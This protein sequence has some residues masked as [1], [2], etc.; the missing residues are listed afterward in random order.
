MFEVEK[1]VLEKCPFC[2]GALKKGKIE[3][4]DAKTLFNTGTFVNFVPEEDEGKFVRKN[5]ISLRQKADG[6]Y[7]DE[8]VQ[9]FGLF[10][11]RY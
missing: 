8:C 3:V 7:C 2:N 6:Y 10:K 4:I 1:L 5:A 9:Y 11:Q